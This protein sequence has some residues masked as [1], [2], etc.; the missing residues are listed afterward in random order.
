VGVIGRLDWLGAWGRLGPTILSREAAN[1]VAPSSLEALF[2][3]FDRLL[4]IEDADA[5]VR[6]AIELAR[7]QI[8]LVRV[9]IYVADG[10]RHLMLGTW[11][12]DSTGAILD[13][14]HVMYAMSGLDR[15]AFCPDEAGA[16]YAV[17]EDCVVVEHRSRRRK[18]AHRGWIA[19]T[20]I[21]CGQEVIGMTFNDAGPSHADFDERK[22]AQVTMLCSVLGPA[23]ASLA[24]AKTKDVP[25]ERLPVHRLVM[26]TIAMIA[27]DPGVGVDQIAR[28]LAVSRRRVTRLFEATLGVSLPEYRNR[29]RL[30]RVAF[31]IAKGDMSLPE[32]A[33]AAGF[34]SDAQ[35][36]QVS[37]TFRWMELLK[38]LSP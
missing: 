36:Q 12:S 31:L 6:R 11:G 24:R 2:S 22:Q 33:V 28:R 10:C 3:A 9:S 7:D 25:S 14:H 8:G 29:A 35:F 15:E 32:A 37:R 1:V 20:P 4:T 19:C 30:D 17:V 13:E 16:P 27:Q 5:I 21:R 26:A 34:T 38:R 23:L 18:I